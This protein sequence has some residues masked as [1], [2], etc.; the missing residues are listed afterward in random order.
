MVAPPGSVSVVVGLPVGS[1][2]TPFKAIRMASSLLMVAGLV[3]PPRG[4]GSYMK[5]RRSPL[6]ASSATSMRP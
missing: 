3:A 6:A 4:P 1:S 5:C 2:P